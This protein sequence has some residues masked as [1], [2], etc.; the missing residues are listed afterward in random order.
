MVMHIELL[1]YLVAHIPKGRRIA[2]TATV[3]DVIFKQGWS[4]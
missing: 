3:A 1:L 2:M 4:Q